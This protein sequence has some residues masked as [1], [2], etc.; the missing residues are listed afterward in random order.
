MCW[1]CKSGQCHLFGWTFWGNICKYRLCWKKNITCYVNS[2]KRSYFPLQCTALQ[3]IYLVTFHNFSC[4]W[5]LPSVNILIKC[6]LNTL[7]VFILSLFPSF[8]LSEPWSSHSLYSSDT[9]VYQQ[10]C[11]VSLYPLRKLKPWLQTKIFPFEST[12]RRFPCMVSM[13]KPLKVRK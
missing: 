13:T 10:L 11:T 8:C 3:S 4:K 5:V 7:S 6:A 12:F 2:K 1:G 9:T